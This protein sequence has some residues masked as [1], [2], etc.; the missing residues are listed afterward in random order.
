[1]LLSRN[2]LHVGLAVPAGTA[3]SSH[4]SFPTLPYLP[5]RVY[6]CPY[7]RQKSVLFLS[8]SLSWSCPCSPCAP[9]QL[10]SFLNI[11]ERKNSNTSPCYQLCCLLVRLWDV[12]LW[13]QSGVVPH[14]S[15]GGGSQGCRLHGRLLG[16]KGEGWEEACGRRRVSTPVGQSVFRETSA[17][18][19]G[20]KASQPS[21]LKGKVDRTGP[22]PPHFLKF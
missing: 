19:A 18:R 12:L 16:F 11:R 21:V 15:L 22:L 2:V 3:L 9:N 20:M 13:A 8:S 14:A 1:M 7:W 10:S 5:V 17:A 4:P 6:G